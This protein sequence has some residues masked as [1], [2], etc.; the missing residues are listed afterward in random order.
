MNHLDQL[1]LSDL[2]ERSVAF[3]GEKSLSRLLSFIT[4]YIYCVHEREG[5]VLDFLPGFQEFIEMHYGLKDNS[6][7]FQH[8]SKIISFFTSTDEEAFDEFYKLLNQ[9]YQSF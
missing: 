3:I 1:L 4:G 9:Y 8:W 7:V 2:K 5:V 6:H